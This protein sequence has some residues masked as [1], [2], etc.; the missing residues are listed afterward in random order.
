MFIR[1]LFSLLIVMTSTSCT[2][3]QM[4]TTRVLDDLGI[5]YEFVDE[6]TFNPEGSA[7]YNFTDNTI[8]F[9][10]GKYELSL[11][12]HE[13]VHALRWE[14]G[15][16]LEDQLLEEVIA[17]EAGFAL[18][19]FS[20]TGAGM[21]KWEK[22]GVRSRT[23]GANGEDRGRRLTDAEKQ[24]IKDKVTETKQIF[25]ERLKQSGHSVDEIDWV[26]TA[27]IILIKEGGLDYD[28]EEM[29]TQEKESSHDKRKVSEDVYIS[30]K[31]AWKAGES[32]RFDI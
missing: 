5:K 19:Q 12:W 22:H 13:S 9:V 6:L 32:G 4:S 16:Y 21:S 17:V 31:E 27:I 15:V 26:K 24:L 8:Y 1:I 28:K 18:G 11:M 10:N 23:L 25:I 14:A 3:Y 29:L 20:K 2:R 30:I 7:E